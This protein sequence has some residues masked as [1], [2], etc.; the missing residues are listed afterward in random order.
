MSQPWKRQTSP[1]VLLVITSTSYCVWLN[2]FSLNDESAQMGIESWNHTPTSLS[3]PLINRSMSQ[4]RTAKQQWHSQV[5]MTETCRKQGG[6]KKVW[7]HFTKRDDSSS[8]RHVSKLII[9]WKSGNMMDGD[10]VV[11]E[12][13]V[14]SA[15]RISSPLFPTA[16]L[17][18]VSNCVTLQRKRYHRQTSPCHV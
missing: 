2:H 13:R 18:R 11:Y 9:W 17:T 12:R 14:Q 15:L 10:I 1:V 16:A 6:E 7:L 4:L 8:C 5:Y 3:I